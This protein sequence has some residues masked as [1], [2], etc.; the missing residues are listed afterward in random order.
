MINA[1]GISQFSNS[2]SFV[3]Q[4]LYDAMSNTLA[5]IIQKDNIGGLLLNGQSLSILNPTSMPAFHPT[6]KYVSVFVNVSHSSYFHLYHNGGEKFG[7][8]LYGR[9]G[10][11]VAYGYALHVE[12]R[13]AEC[14]NPSGHVSTPHY[15]H[16][17][18]QGNGTWCFNCDDMTHLKYCDAVDKC[19]NDQEVCYV[20]RYVGTLGVNMYKSGC[21]NKQQCNINY[22]SSGCFECCRDNFCNSAGCGDN[23]FQEQENRGPMCFD[24]SHKGENELCHAT[25]L[26]HTNQLC[27][28]KKYEWGDNDFQYAM[29]CTDSQVCTSERVGAVRMVR[30]TPLCAQCCRSD[31]CN[32]NCSLVDTVPAIVG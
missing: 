12:L 26:C 14:G 11:N 17:S 5:I 22:N 20:Q 25:K 4:N 28:I 27:S 1:Q 3:T 19:Q 7:A 9:F 13:N 2:Y 6:E 15:P 30:N 29:G 16:I 21:I 18:D 8:V 23:G 31:F 32:M 10:S 24:C